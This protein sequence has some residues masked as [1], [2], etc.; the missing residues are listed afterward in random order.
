MFQVR[1]YRIGSYGNPKLWLRERMRIT[2]KVAGH[3]ET[4]TVQIV[5]KPATDRVFRS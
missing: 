4:L 3:K 1:N 5:F 2:R